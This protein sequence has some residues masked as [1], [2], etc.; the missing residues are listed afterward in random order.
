MS[1]EETIRIKRLITEAIDEDRSK[2][3]VF[4]IFIDAGILTKKGNLKAPY[5]EIYI[6]YEE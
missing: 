6:P 5:K 2:E 1:S 3:E 4:D